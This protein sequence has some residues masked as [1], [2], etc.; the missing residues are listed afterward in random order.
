M[1]HKQKGQLTTTGEWAKHLRNF[2]KRQF[3]KKE[4]SAEK[5]WV[6]KEADKRI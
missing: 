5:G 2:L 4:R 1:A 6:R 3:W